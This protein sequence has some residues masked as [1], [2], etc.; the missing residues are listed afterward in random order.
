[1]SETVIVVSAIAKIYARAIVAGTREFENI[2]PS[3][4]PQV[5]QALLDLGCGT[6]GKPLN[7]EV[8]EGE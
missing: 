5:R 1:M 7:Q 2:S 3:L 8:S 4:Q 6:D